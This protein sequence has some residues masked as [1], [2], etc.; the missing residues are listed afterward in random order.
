[1]AGNLI[2]RGLPFRCADLSVV[3]GAGGWFFSGVSHVAVGLRRLHAAPG[4]AGFEVDSVGE[5]PVWAGDRQGEW[6]ELG[7]AGR[8]ATGD[9]FSVSGWARAPRLRARNLDGGGAAYDS[10][11]RTCAPGTPLQ[12]GFATLAAGTRVFAFSQGDEVWTKVAAPVRV[13]VALYP[14]GRAALAGV[15]G[16]S[17]PRW[18]CETGWLEPS[19]VRLERD[20]GARPADG[21]VP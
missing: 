18:Q 14:K 7:H 2:V 12:M 13:L 20:S 9:G 8:V 19:A 17:W 15:P 11:F 5:L 10:G 21:G 3:R 16:W 6:Q 4:D 1:M